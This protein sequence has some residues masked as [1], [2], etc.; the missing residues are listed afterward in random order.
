MLHDVVSPPQFFHQFSTE[1][2]NN[3][4]IKNYEDIRYIIVSSTWLLQ[5]ST[6]VSQQ[7][8]FKP[9]S[10]TPR[11]QVK[12]KQRHF[13]SPFILLWHNFTTTPFHQVNCM[14]TREI[15]FQVRP[16]YSP[17]ATP[18]R[19]VIVS[20]RISTPMICPFNSEAINT[21]QVRTLSAGCRT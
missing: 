4:S 18:L 17:T 20:S 14:P 13:C 10:L 1:S 6:H 15:H 7:F 19:A 3:K 21:W 11:A 16:Q 2:P 8:A 12:H 5:L 9:T